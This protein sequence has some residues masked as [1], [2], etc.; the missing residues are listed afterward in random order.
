M[1][2]ISNVFVE[3]H[4]IS[5]LSSNFDQQTF[6][7]SPIDSL[8]ASRLSAGNILIVLM[9]TLKWIF[10]ISYLNWQNAWMIHII[11]TNWLAFTFHA[12]NNMDKKLTR[13]HSNCK[14]A[15]DTVDLMLT[16][17]DFSFDIKGSTLLTCCWLNWP[18]IGYSWR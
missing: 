2:N 9:F 14:V 5:Q 18:D 1:I 4:H 3:H 15:A 12:V 10:L 8:S 7:V 17:I 6:W 11:Y 13:K 16:T